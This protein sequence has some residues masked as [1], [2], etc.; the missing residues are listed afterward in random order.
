MFTKLVPFLGKYKKYAILAPL[1]IVGETVLEVTI[2]FLMA[3]IIDVGIMTGDMQYVLR[4]GGIMVVMAGLALVFGALAG[5]FAAVAAAG[6]A[7]NLRHG[8]F[9]KV[10]EF[11]FSNIDKYGTPSLI[12]RLTTDVTNSQNVVMMMLRMLFRA[13]IMMICAT[14]FAVYIN[15]ALS[16]IFFVAVPVLAV[17][18]AVIM[19]KAFPRF[20][21]MLKH[22]DKLNAIV[23]ENLT[24]IRVVKAYVREGEENDK[25]RMAAEQL[26]DSQRQA[27]KLVIFSMPMMQLAMY[28]SMVSIVWFGGNMIVSETME[29]GELMGFLSYVTQILM[30]LMMVAMVFI[31]IVISK[32]SVSRILEVLE[33]EIDIR[34]EA[35]AN[36]C[37]TEEAG[38]DIV[39]EG[40]SFSYAG[41]TDNPALCHID[42]KINSGETV[43]IIGGTGSGKS[44]LVQL[45]P[46]LYDVT[47]GRI[48]LGGIDVRDYPVKALRDKVA[49]VLQKNVLFSG[50]VIDNLKWG[51]EAA[52]D[53]EVVEACKAAAAHDFI[54][55]FPDG[56]ATVLGQGGVNLSGGQKQRL[57]IARALLKSPG[58]IILD[59]STSAVDTDTDS[60]IR[61]ALAERL[62]ETTTIIIAQR[63]ASVMDADK[64]IVMDDGRIDAVGTHEELMASNTIF[65]EVYESQRKGVA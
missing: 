48:L 37:G 29:P 64:I 65:R 24:A 7:K 23:Q 9:K 17:G 31:S 12:T 10:Q 14:C 50:T 53:E 63:I 42:L 54:M 47:E 13:P 61:A 18:L 22:Y 25:F 19:S 1:T 56:Y 60:R 51:N 26:R 4:T 57:C 45:I 62:S 30:S 43:G 55:A 6:F 34:D 27:E 58:V 15:A 32:A 2:P 3:K 8:L 38:G 40:V 21:I 11:S 16:L 59:D 35:D 36:T 41:D 52:S 28:A 5:R 46:R 49:M 44:S 39:F 20:Q 33:E